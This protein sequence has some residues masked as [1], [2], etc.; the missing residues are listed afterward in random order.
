MWTS[1]CVCRSNFVY[2]PPLVVDNVTASTGTG[3]LVGWIS[4][5]RND[6]CTTKRVLTLVTSAM[7]IAA[8]TLLADQEPCGQKIES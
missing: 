4:E 6:P 8:V 3:M 1:S 2:K 7:W 5:G